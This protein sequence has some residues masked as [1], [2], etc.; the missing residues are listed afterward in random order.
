[1]KK[2]KVVFNLYFVETRNYDSDSN[3]SSSN[4]DSH[5][6]SSTTSDYEVDIDAFM[7]ASYCNSIPRYIE[8]IEDLSNT[9][10]CVC[11]GGGRFNSISYKDETITCTFTTNNNNFTKDDL[12]DVLKYNSLEDGEYESE[13]GSTLV[14][15]FGYL[16]RDPS[17][18]TKE[19]GLID[20]RDSFTVE[21]LI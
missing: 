1:M 7:R 2:F 10:E 17:F 15:P 11:D 13:P 12:I 14:Y 5:Y 16:T 3:N 19:I 6:V 20:Y 4:C 8:F 21:E 18:Y 9:C